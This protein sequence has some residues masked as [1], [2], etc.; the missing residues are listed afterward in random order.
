[1]RRGAMG[2]AAGAVVGVVLLAVGAL[3]GLGGLTGCGGYRPESVAV[4]SY[5]VGDQVR[6]L[7]VVSQA[8]AVEV[9]AGTG[10][11]RVTETVRYRGSDPTTAHDVT[12]GTLNLR[13]E[14]CTTCSVSYLVELPAATAVR[15]HTGAG[16]IRL[17][18]LTGDVTA[19]TAA[20]EVEGTGLGSAHTSVH[21]RAGRISLGYRA[22]PSTVDVQTAAGEVEIRLPGTESYAVDAGT[23]AG[24]TTIGVP[25]DPAADRKITAHTVAGKVTI[26]R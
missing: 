9:R 18:G 4:R 13:N 3:V 22:A 20:G 16:A 23:T 12:D 26:T 1:M 17:T 25:T 8:G 24:E 21:S 7:D 5:Q 11:V 10:P 6:R 15:V 19:D 14:D 2:T